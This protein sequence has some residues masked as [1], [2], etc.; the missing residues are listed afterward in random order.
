[1]KQKVQ[2]SFGFSVWSSVVETHPLSMDVIGYYTV[3]RGMAKFVK[4]P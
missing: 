2:K 3:T 4:P 1:M